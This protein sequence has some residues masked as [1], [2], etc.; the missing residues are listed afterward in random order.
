MTQ[1]RRSVRHARDRHETLSRRCSGRIPGRATSASPRAPVRL[2]APPKLSV[3]SVFAS[4]LGSTA[5]SEAESW[6]DGRVGVK[7][8]PFDLYTVEMAEFLEPF[9]AG[10]SGESARVRDRGRHVGRE[11]QEGRCMEVRRN[12]IAA[13]RGR[14][15]GVALREAFHGAAAHPSCT[16]TTPEVSTTPSS[17][18]R[19]CSIRSSPSP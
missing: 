6:P 19:A 13:R 11:R 8:R 10:A 14:G 15:Q 7:K 16:T 4:L 17:I 3:C 9:I 12:S 2:E 1:P 18:G 5:R